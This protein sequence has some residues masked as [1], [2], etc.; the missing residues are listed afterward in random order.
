M[1]IVTK[2]LK[3]TRAKELFSILKEG[4]YMACEGQ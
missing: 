1:N 2:A 3:Y 4:L